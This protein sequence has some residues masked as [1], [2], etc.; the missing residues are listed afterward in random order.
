RLSGGADRGLVPASARG[1]RPAEEV[2]SSRARARPRGLEAIPE[3]ASTDSVGIRR[4][5]RRDDD[6]VSRAIRRGGATQPCD[7]GRWKALARVPGWLL[8]RAARTGARSMALDESRSRERDAT[9]SPRVTGREHR[10]TTLGTP[11]AHEE[12][13]MSARWACCFPLLVPGL[14]PATAV[15]ES[16][17]ASI[18][19]VVPDYTFRDFLAG[20]DGRQKLSEF[21][22][23]PVL[24][25]NWTDTDFGRGA[26]KEAEKIAKELA[27][28]GL[29]T[30]LLDTHN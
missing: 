3:P 1:R 5:A 4:G 24:I 10:T 15:Q 14:A 2:H 19:Q 30:I 28:E 22:G 27:P 6:R 13:R 12:P 8:V 25:V 11:A 26:A 7:E 29:V 23:Q 16:P 17:K 20:S 9:G 18:G 21:L